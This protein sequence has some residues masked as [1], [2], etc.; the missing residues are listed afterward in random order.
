M[1]EHDP[2]IPLMDGDDTQ[3][4][5]W[6]VT[7]DVLEDGKN[8]AV[9]RPVIGDEPVESVT[10]ELADGRVVRFDDAL[11]TVDESRIF[12]DVIEFE[13]REIR[14]VDDD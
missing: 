12:P 2:E 8:F 13:T 9:P 14:G 6:R 7:A 11:G 3:R 4:A 5:V 10:V 1:T